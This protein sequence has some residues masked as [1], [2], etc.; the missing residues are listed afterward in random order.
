VKVKE[1]KK[2]DVE[3]S[4]WSRTW[5]FLGVSQERKDFIYVLDVLR[6]SAAADILVGNVTQLMD[7]SHLD[8]HVLRPEG[9]QN[10]YVVL[11][12]FGTQD[13]ALEARENFIRRM[14]A[15]ISR[16]PDSLCREVQQKMNTSRIMT[17]KE[18]FGE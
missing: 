13:S 18:M 7:T 14:D 3:P 11:G 6:D 15:V 12:G 5:K 4:M 1:V 17:G 10:A 16:Q 8:I 9:K 2:A